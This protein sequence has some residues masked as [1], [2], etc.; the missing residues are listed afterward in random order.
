VEEARRDAGVSNADVER[1]QEVNAALASGEIGV[2]SELLHPDVVW[3]HNVG[4]GSPEEGVYRGRDAVL[5]LYERIFEPWEYLRPE[6]DEIR[7]LGDGSVVVTGHLKAKHATSERVVVA[8]YEQQLEIRD[9]L[10][11]HGRMTTGMIDV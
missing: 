4:V 8:A 1:I 2:L 5:R 3:E 7:A 10:L 11:V 6:P 9:G